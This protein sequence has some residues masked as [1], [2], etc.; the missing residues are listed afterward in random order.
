[1]TKGSARADGVTVLRSGG[2]FVLGILGSAFLLLLAVLSGWSRPVATG[3]ALLGAAACHLLLTHPHVRLDEHAVTL[4]NPVRWVRIPWGL[5]DEVIA[6]LSL[7][8]FTET[9]KFTS[10]AVSAKL[11]RPTPSPGLPSSRDPGLAAASVVRAPEG[12]ATRA[13]EGGATRGGPTRGG[14]MTA[15]R[16]KQLI[17]QAHGEWQELVAAGAVPA[18]PEPA[19]ARGWEW[20]NVGLLAVGAVVTVVGL[21]T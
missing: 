19:V 9:Q 18:P 7:D 11:D 21:L 15:Q 12:A 20:R 8:V 14:S 3:L 2:S 4:A 6:R 10:W 5:L 17:E 13:D 16:A 1:M